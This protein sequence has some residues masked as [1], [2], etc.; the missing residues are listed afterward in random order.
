MV[1][2]F[3]PASVKAL[4]EPESLHA[5]QSIRRCAVTTPLSPIPIQTAYVKQGQGEAP[6]LLLHGFDSSLLEFRYLLPRLATQAETWSVDL[7]G[8]GFTDRPS[9]ITFSPRTIQSHLY[10]FWKTMIGRPVV[11]VGASMGG[12]AAIAFALA[13]PLLVERLVLID[14]LGYTV[15]PPFVKFLFPPLDYWA[16]EYLRQRKLKALELS[17]A[18]RSEAKIIDLIRCSL[19]HTEMVGWHEATISF[20]KSGGYDFLADQICKIRQPTLI[21]WG[22]SDDVLGTADALRFRQD[23]PDSQLA[24]IQDCKHVPHIEQ[25]EVTAQHIL[26]FERI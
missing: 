25:P 7:L 19:L 15:A 22:E 16:V 26:S 23:I 4:T 1:T 21:L 12:A 11:L 2:P 5:V 20:T 8:F 13:Y 17:M 18:L 9:G 14:S 10:E 24:W 6:I 3:L